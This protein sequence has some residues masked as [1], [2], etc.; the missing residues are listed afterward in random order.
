MSAV[1]ANTKQTASGTVNH[2]HSWKGPPIYSDPLMILSLECPNQTGH[3]TLWTSPVNRPSHP[4]PAHPPA[5]PHTPA[6]RDTGIQCKW[7]E[8]DTECTQHHR[9]KASLH[10]LS[11]RQWAKLHKWVTDAPCGEEQTWSRAAV[12]WQRGSVWEETT[13]NTFVTMP[14]WERPCCLATGH[15]A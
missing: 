3:T 5:L 13:S 1:Q 9:P 12:P 14:R 15:Q 10:S 4:H 6:F 2:V 8:G 11:C 7:I